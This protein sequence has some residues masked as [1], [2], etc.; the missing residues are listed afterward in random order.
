MDS[1]EFERLQNKIKVLKD[2]E[3]KA[4]GAIEAIVASWK[5]KY[6]VSTVEEVEALLAEKKAEVT[7]TDELIEAQ[8]KALKQL[9]NWNLL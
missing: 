1:Q 8:Y 9:T 2:K 3:S 6:Q 7:E 4:S 5:E